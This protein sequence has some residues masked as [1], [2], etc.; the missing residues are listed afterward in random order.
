MSPVPALAGIATGAPSV[1][2][3][4]RRHREAATRVAGLTFDLG[5]L[6]LEMATRGRYRVDVLAARAAELHG[7]EAELAVAEHEL[8]AVRDGVTGLCPACHAPHSRGAIHCW[9]CGTPL[10]AAYVAYPP[11]TAG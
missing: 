9:R 8:A 4:E 7:A 1:E 2:E 3:L 10:A 5:G 11:A 6:A